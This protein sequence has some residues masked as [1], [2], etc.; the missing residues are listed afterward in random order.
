MKDIFLK[1]SVPYGPAGLPDGVC[2]KFGPVLHCM[3][4]E[5]SESTF[6]AVI[7]VPGGSYEHCSKREGEP[8]AARWY[9]HGFNSFYTDYTC[10]QP[11]PA[12]LLE[13]AAA[14][15]FIRENAEKLRCSGKVFLCG[16]SA[17]GHLAASL[18][19]YHKR[20]AGYFTHDIRPD[21]LVLCYPV[22]TAGEYT[23]R[24]SAENIAPTEE[25]K[26]IC[27]LENHITKDF[28]PSF[29][30]HCADDTTVS[31]NNSLMLAQSLAAA[32]VSFEAHIFP[33]GGHGIAMCDMTAVKNGDMS[34]INPDAARWF[35]MAL[36]FTERIGLSG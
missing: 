35:G 10:K 7:V 11:F 8:C 12:A 31:V 30:W 36:G 6:P 33:R 20:Y 19:A 2:E 23:H 9:A 18:G 24:I 29:I 25:L 32:G 28:P 3:V 15:S 4:H 17:G 27:S 21:G 26:K 16:F 34:Y 1:E 22:I 14:V 13:L 5:S